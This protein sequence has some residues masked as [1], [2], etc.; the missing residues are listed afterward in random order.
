MARGCEI[1]L[2]M[3]L[4]VGAQAIVIAALIFTIIQ[5]ARPAA[6]EP[7]DWDRY[8]DRQ[9]ACAEKDRIAAQCEVERNPVFNSFVRRGTPEGYCDELALRQ[10]QRAC[11]AFDPLGRGAR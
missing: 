8:H 5:I 11:S 6:N 10:A 4:L 1:L 2:G 9:D 7:F 3:F